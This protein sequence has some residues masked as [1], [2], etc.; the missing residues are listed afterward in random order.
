MNGRLIVQVADRKWGLLQ[1]MKR[2]CDTLGNVAEGNHHRESSME[3][4]TV[5][6][7]RKGLST[8]DRRKSGALESKKTIMSSHR[9]NEHS[10][11]SDDHTMKSSFGP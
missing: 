3:A 5:M 9:K 1:K 7:L 6:C 10:C 4:A 2:I 8:R 11:F